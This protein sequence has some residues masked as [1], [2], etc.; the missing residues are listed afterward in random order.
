[1]MLYRVNAGTLGGRPRDPLWILALG[2]SVD[3]D[4]LLVERS[5]LVTAGQHVV[6]I[7]TSES[8]IYR[9]LSSASRSLSN[10]AQAQY[11]CP[12]PYDLLG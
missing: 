1:M 11:R 10:H 5:V 6:L 12:D 7:T 9:V 8:K 3:N 2:R 4:L